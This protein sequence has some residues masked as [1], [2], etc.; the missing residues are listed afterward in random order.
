MHCVYLY[1]IMERKEGDQWF[2]SS[3]IN[4]YE[5]RSKHRNC[6]KNTAIKAV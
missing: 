5:Y 3:F 4:Q 1:Q 6:E 2:P